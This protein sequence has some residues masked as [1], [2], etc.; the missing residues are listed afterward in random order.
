M[1]GKIIMKFNFSKNAKR[2][3]ILGLILL[4]TVSVGYALLTQTIN[5]IST[6]NLSGTWNIEVTSVEFDSVNST[7]AF[8]YSTTSSNTPDNILLDVELIRPETAVAIYH[9]KIKNSGTIDALLTDA[10]IL[11]NSDPSNPV[12]FDGNHTSSNGPPVLMRSVETIYGAICE[13]EMNS[14][15]LNAGEE[16]ICTFK[17]IWDVYGDGVYPTDNLKIKAI[18]N[19]Q[20]VTT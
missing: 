3:T 16:K 4:T 8:D 17:V 20:Q 7:D 10:Q 13:V 12:P 2:L 9:V 19:F 18:L 1:M 11:D 15:V 14:D 5:I 6:V